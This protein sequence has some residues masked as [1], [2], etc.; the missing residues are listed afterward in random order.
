M[1]ILYFTTDFSDANLAYAKQHG[2]TVRDGL[3]YREIDF[4]E[5]CDKVCGDVPD[6]YRHL[7]LFDEKLDEKPKRK[8]R[9]AQTQ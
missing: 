4:I 5:T 3:A 7:P 9:N 6:A 8:V 2:L 1:K